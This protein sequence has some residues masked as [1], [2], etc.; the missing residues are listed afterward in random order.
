MNIVVIFDVNSGVELLK[1]ELSLIGYYSTW[2]SDGRKVYLPSRTMWKT[3]TSVTEARNEVQTAINRINS[4][5]V[6]PTIVLQRFL[7]VPASPWAAIYGVE[8][9]V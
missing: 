5:G 4:K 6:V 1:E 2:L 9:I 7:A 8:S 3:D